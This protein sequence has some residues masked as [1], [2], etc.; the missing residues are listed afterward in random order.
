MLT[1]YN[2]HFLNLVLDTTIS[3]FPL[4]YHNL[5]KFLILGGMTRSLESVTGVLV[6]KSCHCL[7]YYYLYSWTRRPCL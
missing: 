7:R 2:F 4:F 6:N 5:F 1:F 3:A